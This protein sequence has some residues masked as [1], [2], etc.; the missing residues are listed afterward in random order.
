MRANEGQGRRSMSRISYAALGCG[1]AFSAMGFASHSAAQAA[2]AS[3]PQAE[4][5]QVEEVVVS[6]IR[7]T[8]QTSIAV[9]RDSVAIV[10]ALSSKEIGDL[11]GQS[12]GEAIETI[13]GATADR[14]N[15]G[16]TEVS[17][18][19]LGSFL[20]ATT[21]NGREASNGSG[22][23]A[24]NFGQ[25][26]SELFNGI[27]IYKSQQA[28]LIEGGVAGSIEL[29]TQKPLDYGKR[30][31]SG[32]IKGNYNSYQDR[33]RGGSPWGWRGTASYVDQFHTS[34]L[35]D[36]GI[37][38]GVQRNAVDDPNEAYVAS[39]TWVACNPRIVAA[40]NCTEVSRA[41]ASAGTPF[42]LAPNSTTYRQLT[43]HETRDALFGALQWKPN[44]RLDVNL[45]FEYSKRKYEE[46]RH[47]FG[48][49]ETRYNLRNVQ[50]APDGT[51]LY[52]EGSSTIQSVSTLFQREERY[53]G[54]GASVALEAT[55]HL[56]LSGDVSYS[57]TVRDDLTRSVRLRTDPLD[58][59]GVR[60]VFNNQRIPYVYDARNGFAPTITLDPRFN[61]DDYTLY[62]DDTR[63]TREGEQKKDEIFAA[64]FDARYDLDG[65]LSRIE[66]GGRFSRRQ[67]T[68]YD[69]TVT[70]DLASLAVDKTVN[71][72]CRT[73]FPQTGFLS[74][75]PNNQ[76]RSWATFNTL[77]Q[78][79][80]Y[81][82][83]EDPGDSGDLRSVDNADVTETVWSGY[84]MGSY[85]GEMGATPVRGN[86]GVR[87]VD[88]KVTSKGLRAGLNVITN[89]DG[90]IRLQENGQFE[91][92][93]VK[94]STFRV[95]PSVNANF[96]IDPK[97]VVRVAGYRAMSR[98]APSSLTAGR[99]ITLEDGTDFTSIQDAIG[100]IVASGSPRLKPIMSWNGD[101]AIERYPNRDTLLAATVY[102]KQ[103]TGGFIP[104]TT[105]EQFVIGGQSVTV[106]VTQ[107]T[108]SKEKSHVYGVELTVANRFSWLPKPLDGF[109]G[110]VS[111]NYAVSNFKNYDIRL[112]DVIDPETQE[113]TP[114]MIPAANLNGYSKHVLSAQ[115]YYDAGPFNIQGIYRLRSKFYQ[116]F[117]GGNAQL[118]YI[119]GSETFDL[120]ASYK[121]N[122][123]IDVRFQALNLF[124]EV[125][126]DS[127]PV[128]GS[129][130]N[131]QYF[132]PQFFIGVRARL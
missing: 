41:Q 14:G 123:H 105:D 120:S 70:I 82:G 27:K 26:P 20:S 119:S 13:T 88:T 25:F 106:P 56:T 76:I 34:K 86:F 125:K 53:V 117:V 47:D 33:I 98:P 128:Y 66:A 127:M 75:A 44:D 73:P 81:L 36:I 84:V 95:L 69:D 114:G 122:R 35:G 124:N 77:C 107:T 38:L 16:P 112:G 42:Y 39:N 7:Q 57:Q 87:L 116:D 71:L 2:A 12:I 131:Y 126:I 37:S 89:G 60:T 43:A 79:Q 29:E 22:D 32:E 83:T 54:G 18:R 93:S 5:E 15:Y 72:A 104:V 21:F 3:A 101:L 108:N 28:D 4:A 94:A 130:R 46:D 121:L 58:I 55:D 48:L 132:G 40:A 10:D 110:K 91:T 80:N 59:N 111:Y 99:A 49:A 9:K 78:F 64:R 1:V 51:L 19:G 17:L 62:S 45:D 102:Y 115:L 63:L 103:F 61:A 97:T 100:D 129:T 8:M 6:A 109:G 52:A 30:L 96:D 31:V 24:V 92:T 23:R 65:F 90:S 74:D 11:P 85:K 67:Y 113:V 118:R 68:R 50:Y